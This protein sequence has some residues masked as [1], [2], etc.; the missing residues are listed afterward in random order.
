M[1]KKTILRPSAVLIYV[2]DVQK[3]LAWYK[4]AFPQA[5]DVYLKEFNLTIL[6]VDGFSLEVVQADLKVSPGKSGKV[7]Y[8]SVLDLQKG[9]EYLQSL[10]ATLYRKPMAIEDGLGMCQMADPF[11]NLIG[12]KGIYQAP[13]VT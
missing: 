12:L 10:G 8:W 7:L 2:D 1:N 5:R 11:G 3:G 6:D 4:Q 9:V 13:S